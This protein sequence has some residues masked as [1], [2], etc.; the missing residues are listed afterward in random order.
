MRSHLSS[1]KFVI[2]FFSNEFAGLHGLRIPDAR[3]LPYG[4]DT[5]L[6]AVREDAVTIKISPMVENMALSKTIE[7]HSLTKKMERDG[8]KVL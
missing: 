5:K 2:S 4:T 7:I 6:F 1:K 8:L 3:I